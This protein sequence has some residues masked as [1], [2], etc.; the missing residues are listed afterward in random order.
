VLVRSTEDAAEGSKK[1]FK[2]AWD[3]CKNQIQVIKR[4]QGGGEGGR[5]TPRAPAI[6]VKRGPGGA[7]GRR[8]KAMKDMKEGGTTENKTKDDAKNDAKGPHEDPQHEIWTA[9]TV[10]MT[11]TVKIAEERGGGGEEGGA[12]AADAA[13]TGDKG[14]EIESAAVPAVPE[15]PTAVNSS[16]IASQALSPTPFT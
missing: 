16:E 1:M 3:D 11:D 9:E 6:G 2:E 15:T 5:L 4:K 10:K 7:G 13:A 14:N 12:T 8:G